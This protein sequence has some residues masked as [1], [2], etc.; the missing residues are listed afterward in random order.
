MQT[1]KE[2]ISTTMQSKQKVASR[3][4]WTILLV[5]AVL[6]LVA[7]SSRK[8]SLGHGLED[9][10]EETFGHLGH[11]RIYGHHKRSPLP[12][13][14]H[15]SDPASPSAKSLEMTSQSLSPS[16][17][18]SQ[19]SSTTPSA[20]QTQQAIPSVPDSANP[21]ILPTPF[22]Q[23]YDSVGATSNLSTTGCINFFANMTQESSFR[24][25]RALSLLEMNSQEFLQVSEIFLMYIL[26]LCV[27][28]PSLLSRSCHVLLFGFRD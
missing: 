11:E 2:A 19:S 20:S 14:I 24:T 6:I 9:I 26:V 3:T 10:A 1:S 4:R 22:P 28:I 15:I 17:T 13:T 8:I 23:P 16:Q 7:I 12:Q 25:C 27:Q 18:S 21:P 5:P